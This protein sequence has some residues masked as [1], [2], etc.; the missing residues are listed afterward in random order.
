MDSNT[1]VSFRFLPLNFVLRRAISISIVPFHKPNTII[2]IVI[3]KLRCRCGKATVELVIHVKL[4]DYDI[5]VLKK[6]TNVS[7]ITS[8]VFI[9]TI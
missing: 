5:I 2:S 3:T 7:S 8:Y 6:Y 1:K 9:Y 4:F